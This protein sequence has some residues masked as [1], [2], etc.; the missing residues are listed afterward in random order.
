LDATEK[1]F[2][3][4]SPVTRWREANPDKTGEEDIVRKLMRGIERLL[5]EAGVEKGKEALTGGVAG[6]LLMVKKKV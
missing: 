1:F 5:H 6:V 2:D 3:T 4:I